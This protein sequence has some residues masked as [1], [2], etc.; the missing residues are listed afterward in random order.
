MLTFRNS[1]STVP[2]VPTVSSTDMSE[3]PDSTDQWITAEAHHIAHDM[4]YMKIDVPRN[5]RYVH[6]SHL[7]I[8]SVNEN[9]TG[10]SNDET[11]KAILVGVTLASDSGDD[12]LAELA[13]LARA[14]GEDQRHGV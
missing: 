14:A 12:D 5:Q 2:A 4:P 9:G 10:L 7:P 1:G 13:E 8:F 3:I 11:E 6:T